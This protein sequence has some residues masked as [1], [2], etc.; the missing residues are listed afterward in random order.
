MAVNGLRLKYQAEAG[1][2]EAESVKGIVS[3]PDRFLGVIVLR[4]T[5]A[6][7][8]AASLLTYIFTEYTAKKHSKIVGFAGS[9]G[10]ALIVLIFCELS[11]K[12]IAEAHPEKLR[13]RMLPWPR[14]W[15]L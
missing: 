2:R 10:S 8:T 13:L 1:D 15:F 7:I 3:N 12:I 14:E 9:I 4:V 11:P 6:E 5:A